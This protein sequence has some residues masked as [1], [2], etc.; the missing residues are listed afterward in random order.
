LLGG[1]CADQ[2]GGVKR[3]AGIKQ[4]GY[5]PRI[6]RLAQHQQPGNGDRR[7]DRLECEFVGPRLQSLFVLALC[8]LDTSARKGLSRSLRVC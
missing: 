4:L 6:V 5:R 8:L 7:V 1:H 3:G 2:L